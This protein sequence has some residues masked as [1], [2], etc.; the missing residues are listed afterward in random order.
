[1]ETDAELR[2]VVA[3][4]LMGG[5]ASRLGGRDKAS[6]VVGRK[7]CL[8]H[9]HQ[10][11]STHAETVYLSVASDNRSFSE[12]ALPCIRD[13]QTG[14]LSRGV[15]DVILGCLRFVRENTDAEYLLTSPVDTPFLPPDY[16][17]RMRAVAQGAQPVVACAHQRLHGLH[18]L[19]PVAS[20]VEISRLVEEV[21]I[22]RIFA[23]H[24]EM[25]SIQVDFPVVHNVDPF[26][27]INTEQ[28]LREARVLAERI[29]SSLFR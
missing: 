23:L 14:G 20:E 8:E 17:S 9:V 21:G 24:E 11:L 3:V 10:A 12:T 28:D 13:M 29:D 16:A 6:L 27:N 4:I 25:K 26:Y 18:A 7:T 1:M 15:A 2:R 5:K 19:W 22:R